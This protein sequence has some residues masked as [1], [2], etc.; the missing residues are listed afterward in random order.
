MAE[1]AEEC[2]YADNSHFTKAITAIYHSPP[3]ILRR[4]MIE[5]SRLD[6]KSQILS[7]QLHGWESNL[8]SET[9]R[10]HFNIALGKSDI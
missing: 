6:I 3:H 1:I 4:E 7:E 9:K 8:D 2:G 10:E 5:L